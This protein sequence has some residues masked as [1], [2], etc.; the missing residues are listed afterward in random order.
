MTKKE[1]AIV[2]AYTGVLLGTFPDM[3]DYVE[4]IMGRPFYTHEFAHKETV[5]AIK[6]KSKSDFRKIKINI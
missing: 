5:D 3:H 1:A 6:E 4:K 2:S